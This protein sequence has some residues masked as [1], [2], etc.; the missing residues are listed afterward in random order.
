MAVGERRRTQPS[1]AGRDSANGGRPN[2]GNVKTWR[3]ANGDIGYAVRFFD[4]HG[5]RQHERC[6][7]ES[8]G[9]SHRRAEIFLEQRLDEVARGVYIPDPEPL[10]TDDSDPLFREFAPVVLAEHAVTVEPNTRAFNSNMLHNHLLPEFGEMRLSEITFERIDEF[11]RRRIQLMQQIKTAEASGIALR[12]PDGRRLKLA[13]KTINHSISVLD[14]VLA[15]AVQRRSIGVAHNEARD[16]RL[17]VKIPK[18]TVRDWL[19]GDELLHLLEVAPRTDD[20]VKPATRERARE[21]LRLRRDCRLT[22]DQTARAMGVAR[23]TVWA[24]SRL[25]LEE[26]RVSQARTIVAILSASGARNTEVCLLRPVDL[27]FSHGKIR[28]TKSKTRRGVREIDMTPWLREQL[29]V[30]IGQLDSGHDPLATLFASRRGN[31]LNKDTLNDILQRVYRAAAEARSERGLPP[32][33]VDLT[34]HVFRRSYITHMLEAGAPPSYVQEQVGHEDAR[35]TLEIY[36][37]VL[38]NRDRRRHVAA[39]D[40]IMRGAA[41]DDCESSP[42]HGRG[43]R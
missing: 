41:P 24:L 33:P 13:P 3:R 39:F 34:A 14:L 26:G 42:D 25:P 28:V 32:I 16:R 36:S 38:R 37:R 43:R 30:W 2:T 23:S 1:R 22:I 29:Q 31:S 9:W 11:K 12:G 18:K 17:R 40:E 35:T 21:V 4:Q 10:D 5:Q 27:D 7:L 6:G 19:E 8:E 15:K 20:P